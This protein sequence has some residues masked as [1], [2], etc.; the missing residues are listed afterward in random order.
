MPE[1]LPESLPIFA[2][3]AVGDIALTARIFGIAGRR[4]AMGVDAI[5]GG[6]TDIAGDFAGGVAGI[7]AGFAG[8]ARVVDGVVAGGDLGDALRMW[9]DSFRGGV[10]G[11]A[12]VRVTSGQWLAGDNEAR[13]HPGAL[14]TPHVIIE[15]S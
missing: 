14:G 2:G 12:R 4:L 13:R 9:G 5:A 7:V 15:H 8:V 3:M 10:C 11:E 6:V 1:S